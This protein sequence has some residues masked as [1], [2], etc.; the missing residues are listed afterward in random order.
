MK[1]ALMTYTNEGQAKL[2]QG[3]LKSNNIES[4]VTPGSGQGFAVRTDVV[5]G[6]DGNWQL[7]ISDRDLE[8]AKEVLEIE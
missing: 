5:T 7:F 6:L 4:V 8:K 1:I 3:L 2:M